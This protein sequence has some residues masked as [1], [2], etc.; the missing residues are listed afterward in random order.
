MRALRWLSLFWLPVH[1][2][3]YH[4]DQ[5]HGHD[6]NDGTVARPVQTIARANELAQAGDA[7]AL[8]RGQTW[9]EKLIVHSHRTYTSY[10]PSELPPPCLDGSEPLKELNWQPGVGAR[11]QAVLLQRPSSNPTQLLLNGERLQRARHPNVGAGDWGTTSRYLRIDDQTPGTPHQLTMRRGSI[12]NRANLVG[13]E[14]FVRNVDYALLHYRVERHVD[15]TLAVQQLSQD[16]DYE[17]RP[18]WG[19]W[20]ENQAWMLDAPGEW[21]YDPDLN[22]ITVWLPGG[23]SPQKQNLRLATKEHAIEAHGATD[24][25]IQDLMVR[26]TTDDA[27]SM[28][29]VARATLRRI[30]IE[31]AGGKGIRITA[32][33][34][35][36]L[37]WI[38]VL[39][40]RQQGVWM[41]DFRYPS[42]RPSK[43]I[44]L[45]NSEIIGAGKNYYAHSAVMLG[46]GGSAVRNH[47]EDAAYIGIHAWRDNAILG[48]KLINTCLQFDD[49]GAIYTISR[50]EH[51]RPKGYALNLQIKDNMIVHAPGS[52]DGSPHRG[53]S[54]RGIYLDDFSRQVLVENNF[55][56]GTDVGI[57]LHFA[58]DNVV[59]H[60]VVVNNRWTQMWLQEN[61][62]SQF[63]CQA[64]YP[65]DARNYISGNI[66]EHNTL[67][68][69]TGQEALWLQTDFDST[70]DFGTF[71]HN[72]LWSDGAHLV[73]DEKSRLL[74]HPARIPQRLTADNNDYRHLTNAEREKWRRVNEPRDFPS[75]FSQ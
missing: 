62:P 33:S 28:D 42:P 45:T 10:G 9:S 25:V 65:C 32:S 56:T 54:T 21:H 1:A 72:L 41:G 27:I 69:S 51:L 29:G 36:T 37:D 20:L 39:N 15:H 18:G 8:A 6:R 60:N 35:S 5:V 50:G 61:A 73:R 16:A 30:R 55:V 11:F 19:F 66:I 14:V 43:G 44:H 71:S 24:F 22:Q 68:S 7:I 12:P 67:I 13:A 47:I 64:L 4:V 31:H 59:R 40:P 23:S 70:E 58:R 63:N 48:N 34:D 17:I 52:R 74:R 3:T 49:C 2:A 26:N 57:H 38:S 53:T 46:Q 75:A